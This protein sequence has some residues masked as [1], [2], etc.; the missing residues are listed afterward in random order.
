M[1]DKYVLRWVL[2]KKYLPKPGKNSQ[3]AKNGQGEQQICRIY[4]FVKYHLHS[5][6]VFFV[7]SLR[8]IVI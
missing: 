5:R 2:P 1:A 4:G 3:Q 8:C 6:R 7:Y